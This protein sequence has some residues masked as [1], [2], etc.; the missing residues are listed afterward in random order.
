MNVCSIQDCGQKS[1]ARKLCRHHYKKWYKYGDPLHVKII[2]KNILCL[3]PECNNFVHAKKHCSMH[4]RHIKK[5]GEIK[6]KQHKNKWINHKTIETA[7]WGYVTKKDKDECWEWEGVIAGGGYGSLWFEMRQ[8]RAHRISYLINKGDIPEGLFV[9]H[10]C[11]NRKCV[12][13]NHLSIGTHSDNMRDCANKG[14]TAFKKGQ[15]IPQLPGRLGE[16]NPNSKISDEQ[17]HEIVMKFKNGA[18]VR[19]IMHEYG[20][21]KTQSHRYRIKARN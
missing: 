4:Y 5:Y 12:N 6:T 20:L 15:P 17:R 1:I 11:D 19:Q 10:S 8:Y 3:V 9:M 14:R 18:K 2:Y 13:P 16:L 7:F 21:S